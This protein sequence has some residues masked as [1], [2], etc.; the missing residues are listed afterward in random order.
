MPEP[1]RRA[2][3]GPRSGQV[4]C[5]QGVGAGCAD[6][7]VRE[8]HAGRGLPWLGHLAMAWQALAIS[9]LGCLLV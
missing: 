2:C 9:I 1:A 4:A 3:A 5:S 8:V 6:A 7:G